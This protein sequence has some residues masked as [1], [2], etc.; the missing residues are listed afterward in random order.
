MLKHHYRRLGAVLVLLF[1]GTSSLSVTYSHADEKDV[2]NP[3]SEKSGQNSHS[4][5][6]IT[7]KIRDG[8]LIVQYFALPTNL[9]ERDMERRLVLDDISNWAYVDYGKYNPGIVLFDGKVSKIGQNL[10][11]IYLIKEI[12]NTAERTSMEELGYSIIF[13]APTEFDNLEHM[14]IFL[15]SWHKDPNVSQMDCSN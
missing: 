4:K 14:V 1:L 7:E 3:I 6:I 8:K 10:W 5:M 11:N 12:Q 9:T 13:S 2:L 15:N